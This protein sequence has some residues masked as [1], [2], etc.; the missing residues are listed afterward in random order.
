MYRK[1]TIVGF[2]QSLFFATPR[3]EVQNLPLDLAGI[4]G[5]SVLA[6]VSSVVQC[7][8]PVVLVAEQCVANNNTL[9]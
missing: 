2:I 6:A 4:D 7:E 3:S 9:Q 1:K 8:S 5:S